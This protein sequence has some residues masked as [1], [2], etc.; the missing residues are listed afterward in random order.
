MPSQPHGGVLVDRVLTGQKREETERLLPDLPI[1]PISEQQVR[2]VENLAT[3]VFSPLNGF[4]GQ[5]DLQAVLFK[6]RLANGAPWTVPIV[7]DVTEEDA[8]RYRE[9]RPIA[10]TFEG[11]AVGILHVT[12]KHTWRREE[13]ALHVF[14]TTSPT[15]PGVADALRMKEIL[16]AGSVDFLEAPESPFARYR[17]TPQETR[18]LFEA[19]GWRTV[20]GFQTRNL[21]HIG[22]EALQKTALSFVRVI[23]MGIPPSYPPTAVNGIQ[24][25]C[26]LTP[27]TGRPYTYPP[28]VKEEVERAA[29]GYVF[30]VSDFRTDDKDALLK[31]IYEKTRK[32]FAVARH[33]LKTKPWDFFMMVEMGV[34]RIHHGFWKFMDP[35]H[36]KY[37]TGNPYE[38]AIREYYR[39]VDAEVGEVLALLPEETVVLVVS[40]HGTKKMDGGICFNEWLMQR[41]YLALK[42]YPDQRTPIDKVEIDWSRTKAWGD[43]GYYG[44]LFLN[45]KGREPQ[46]IVDPRDAEKIRTDLISEIEAIQDPAGK[47]IDSRAYRPEDLHRECRGAPSDLLVYFGNLDWRSVGAVG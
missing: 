29:G 7:L 1:L 44:R 2:E 20:V 38:S 27:S 21:P 40:D 45:I 37:E 5:E 46:G 33:L 23:L 32:H 16:L 30:D 19:K 22:H 12:E 47:N 31:R 34:D 24:V 3:C 11:K 26:F 15:H 36:P 25:G 4:L 43:G 9:G 14:G 6:K 10:L 41:G 39:Y 8:R 28:E 18:V 17:L 35:A 13:Y 42:S